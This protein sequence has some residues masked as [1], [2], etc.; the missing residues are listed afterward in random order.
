MIGNPFECRMA[1]RALDDLVVDMARAH[2]SSSMY[3]GPILSCLIRQAER[4]GSEKTENCRRFSVSTTFADWAKG[5]R[6]TRTLAEPIR[7]N[8]AERTTGGALRSSI[9]IQQ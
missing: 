5:R 9:R 4:P 1:F 7:C 6:W 8:L 3:K 2:R